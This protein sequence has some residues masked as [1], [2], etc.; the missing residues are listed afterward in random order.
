MLFGV[1]E[2]FVGK[3]NDGDVVERKYEYYTLLTSL[4]NYLKIHYK[5]D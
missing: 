5:Q 4:R 2:K 1:R 3:G